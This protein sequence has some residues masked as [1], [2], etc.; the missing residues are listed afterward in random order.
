MVVWSFRGVR[1]NEVFPITDSFS[2]PKTKPPRPPPPMLPSKA[3]SL[4]SSNN[5]KKTLEKAPSHQEKKPPLPPKP[6]SPFRLRGH[7]RYFQLSHEYEHIAV[8]TRIAEHLPIK[9]CNSDE[10]LYAMPLKRPTAV[11][12]PVPLHRPLP[13]KRVNVPQEIEL[14]YAATDVS[15]L[16]KPRSQ[17]EPLDVVLKKPVLLERDSPNNVKRKLFKLGKSLDHGGNHQILPKI[18]PRRSRNGSIMTS[19]SSDEDSIAGIDA[20]GSQQSVDSLASDRLEDVSKRADR[21]RVVRRRTIA[22]YDQQ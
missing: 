18:I 11:A 3:T 13:K 16:T 12:P 5:V 6:I 2:C 22:F 7:P 21:A 20:N 1:M 14:H 19:E 15:I 9:R 10:E 8:E 17:S 4:H